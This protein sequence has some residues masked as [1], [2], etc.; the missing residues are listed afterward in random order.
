MLTLIVM[1][2]YVDHQA[3]VSGHHCMPQYVPNFILRTASPHWY[4]C[5]HDMLKLLISLLAKPRSGE[6]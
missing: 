5:V 6:M 2:E 4:R 1:I 3:A